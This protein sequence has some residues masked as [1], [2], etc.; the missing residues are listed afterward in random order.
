MATSSYSDWLNDYETR[1][2]QMSADEIRKENH[3]D[4]RHPSQVYADYLDY[5]DEWTWFQ[6]EQI[7]ALTSATVYSL[8]L[9]RQKLK[10][11]DHEH[12]LVRSKTELDNSDCIVVDAP[13]RAIHH[14]CWY[15]TIH[16]TVER[17]LNSSVNANVRLPD[18]LEAALSRIATWRLAKSET[19]PTLLPYDTFKTIW[20]NAAET[21]G[22]T[23]LAQD[24][25]QRLNLADRK[26]IAEMQ[27]R[28][29][30]VTQ[31]EQGRVIYWF[32]QGDHGLHTLR[33]TLGEDEFRKVLR[34][35]NRARLRRNTDARVTLT[36]ITERQSRCRHCKILRPQRRLSQPGIY[37]AP[38]GIGKTTALNEELLIGVD[39]DW[40]GTQVTWLEMSPLLNMRI[41]IITNQSV[42]FV[43]SG[44]KIVGVYNENIRLDEFG[45]PYTTVG[46]IEAHAKAQ[47]RNYDLTRV[48]AETH[49]ADYVLHMQIKHVFQQMIAEHCINSMPFYRAGVDE[50]WAKLWTKLIKNPENA[51]VT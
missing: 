5:V 51:H 19:S 44:M 2:S 48:A 23:K 10:C 3:E 43:G 31:P 47:P 25:L 38:P 6:K 36:Q 22:V 26:R 21:G 15:R 12:T 50:E 33:K 42:G 49:F 39:T 17:V 46:I 28:E 7:S 20:W 29:L 18:P 27:T 4:E 8:S 16:T 37:Y 40:I 14:E 41:P 24:M 9:R 35:I 32:P 11:G 45:V 30:P 13:N 1:I 34:F